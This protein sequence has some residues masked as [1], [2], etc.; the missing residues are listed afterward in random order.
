MMSAVEGSNLTY[1]N[2][3][4]EWIQFA[5][6]TLEAYAQPIELALGEVIP[7]GNEVMLDWDSM[8]RSDTKT[9]AETYEILIRCGVLTVNEA[10]A[11]EGMDPLPEPSGQTES[12]DNDG[13]A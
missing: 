3:E 6:F 8:R 13:Q 7:R 11:K 1:S 10:R 9:K 4:Q 5:D 12:E 2:I